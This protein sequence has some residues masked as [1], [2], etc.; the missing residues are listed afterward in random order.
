MESL[1]SLPRNVA[2]AAL[3]LTLALGLVELLTFAFGAYSLVASVATQVSRVES[4]LL[5][6]PVLLIF[7]AGPLVGFLAPRR[8]SSWP[9]AALLGLL[10]GFALGF[11]AGLAAYGS[12]V[13]ALAGLC[14]IGLT[15]FRVG[16]VRHS[17]S[18]G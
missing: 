7:Y 15:R 4:V 3:S 13:G 14:A 18:H 11:P 12:L 5:V 1:R 6:S 17:R 16:T 10:P 2:I 9:L 8:W